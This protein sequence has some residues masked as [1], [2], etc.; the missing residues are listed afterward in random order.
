MEVSNKKFTEPCS[1]GT[2]NLSRSGS[3]TVNEYRLFDLDDVSVY[4][5]ARD[6]FMCDYRESTV[7]KE[8]QCPNCRCCLTCMMDYN[9][10]EC[11]EWEDAVSSTEF[12]MPRPDWKTEAVQATFKRVDSEEAA[13]FIQPPQDSDDWPQDDD[14]QVTGLWPG[15][16]GY[17]EELPP[18]PQEKRFPCKVVGNTIY[19]PDEIW[20]EQEEKP[21]IMDITLPVNHGEYMAIT[22]EYRKKSLYFDRWFRAQ[23]DMRDHEEFLQI[24]NEL[25]EDVKYMV[26]AGGAMSFPEKAPP[27]YWS[28]LLFRFKKQRDMIIH[29]FENRTWPVKA[30]AGVREDTGEQEVNT[31][32]VDQRESTHDDG[33]MT[34]QISAPGHGISMPEGEYH[35][36][37]VMAKPILVSTSQWTTSQETGKQI[38]EVT[39]PGAFINGPHKNLFR[40]FIFTRTEMNITIKV[41]STKFNAGTLLATFVP[42]WFEQ[43]S[44]KQWFA[45]GNLIALPHGKIDA[46]LSN[47]ITLR[48]PFA[49]TLTYFNTA[50]ALPEQQLG[51]LVLS[52]F[53]RLLTTTGASPTVDITIWV[54]FTNCELHQP[55]QLHPIL[56]P[57]VRAEAGVE[58]LVKSV[59]PM[60]AGAIPGGGALTALANTAGNVSGASANCDKPTD[61]Q[62][63]HR[64]VPNAV[65][66]L[67]YGEGIDRTNRLSLKPGTATQHDAAMIQTTEDD[68]SL[69]LLKKVKSRL[70]VFNVSTSDPPGHLCTQ[71]PTYPSLCTDKRENTSVDPAVDVFS[72]PVLAYISRPFKFYRGGLVYTFIAAA[73]QMMACRL[74]ISFIPGQTITNFEEASY[75]NTLI[76]DIQE[77]HEITFTTPYMNNRPWMRCDKLVAVA[78]YKQQ[79]VE[80]TSGMVVVHVV[81]RLTV[82]DAA[83]KSIEVNVLISA[84]DDFELAFPSDLSLYQGSGDVIAEAGLSDTVSARE[85]EPTTI[86]IHGSG[87]LAPASATTLSENAMDLKTVCRRYYK[88]YENVINID[89]NSMI[90][91]VNTP[92]LSS[93]NK[94]FNNN[95]GTQYR[96]HISHFA[97][98]FVFWRGSLRY[99]LT[100]HGWDTT[101]SLTAEIVHVPGVFRNNVTPVNISDPVVMTLGSAEAMGVQVGTTQIQ[102]S[103]QFEIPFYTPFQQLRTQYNGSN[104]TEQEATGTIFIRFNGEK[105]TKHRITLYQALG[106][107]ASFNYFRGVPQVQF[108]NLAEGARDTAPNAPWIYQKSFMPLPEMGIRDILPRNPYTTIMDTVQAIGHTSRTTEELI[109]TIQSKISPA[110]AEEEPPKG[111]GFLDNFLQNLPSL[112]GTGTVVIGSLAA[113]ITG[114]QAFLTAETLIVKASAIVTIIREIFGTAVEWS[115]N[116]LSQL[117][118]TIVT[119]IIGNGAKQGNQ[120][121]E[122][123][124]EAQILDFIPAVIGV[125]TAALVV[126]GFKSI[127]DDKDTKELCNNISNKLRLFNFG[128]SAISNIKT[129]YKEMKEFTE[130]IID[131]V[132]TLTAPQFLA[133]LRLQRGYEEI[134]QWA[135]FI[136]ATDRTDYQNRA[137]YDTD[138][139]NEIY[140]TVDQA[141]T[142]T[143]LMVTGK[144]GREGFIIRDLVRRAYEMGEKVKEAYRTIAFRVDPLCICLHGTTAMG[145]STVATELGMTLLDRLGY[146]RKNRWV[147]HN[148]TDKFF[149]ENYRGQHAVYIDDISLFDNPEQYQNFANLKANTQLPLNMALRKGEYFTSHFLITTTNVKYPV[150]NTCNFNPALQRRRDIMIECSWVNQEVMQRAMAGDHAV[151]E[152]YAHIRFRIIESI[153]PVLARQLG[154]QQAPPTRYMT[155]ADLIEELVVRSHHYLDGQ[156][157][158]VRR[159]LEMQGVP[160]PDELAAINDERR[161]HRAAEEVFH[162]AVQELPGNE[163]PIPPEAWLNRPAP[164]VARDEELVAEEP[165]VALNPL[166]EDQRRLVGPPA[167]AQARVLDMEAVGRMPNLRM[168]GP[169]FLATLSWNDKLQRVESSVQPIEDRVMTEDEV[170]MEAERQA[171]FRMA[172]EQRA[173]RARLMM[174]EQE[175]LELEA[176]QYPPGFVELEFKLSLKQTK[177]EGII[178]AVREKLAKFRTWAEHKWEEIKE[179]LPFLQ[180]FETMPVKLAGAAVAI[181]GLTG[182]AVK[183][184]HKCYCHSVR[185][186]GYRCRLCGRWPKLDHTLNQAWILQ[187]WQRIYGT[188]EY[189][190]GRVTTLEEEKRYRQLE[191]EETI[192]RMTIGTKEAC[193]AQIGPYSDVTRGLHR[194]VLVPHMGPYS[195]VTK[196]VA[197]RR[198]VANS[199][200]SEILD[201]RIYSALHRVKV[202]LGLQVMDINALAVGGKKFLMQK[203]F[204][205]VVERAGEFQLLHSGKWVPVIYESERVKNFPNKDLV[206]VEIPFVQNMK[207]LVN[208]FIEEESLGKIKKT[209]AVVVKVNQGGIPVVIETEAE[210][211]DQMR[212][213]LELNGKTST[214]VTRGMWKYRAVMGPGTC[215]SVVMTT[216]NKTNGLILGLHSAGDA[217]RAI[218]YASLITREMLQG[219]IGDGKLG[220]PLPKAQFLISPLI[221]DGHFGHIGKVER[222]IFQSDKTTIIPTV[223]Q[224]LVAPVK[225]GPAPL[226]SKDPRIEKPTNIIRECISKYG[227]VVKP[228]DIRHRQMISEDLRQEFGTW[229]LARTPAI[230]SNEEALCGIEELPGFDRL[231]LNTSPGYPWVLTRPV[232]A[233]GKAYLFDIDNK[234]ISDAALEK[235]FQERERM[236]LLGE[237]VE[238]VWTCCLKDE[239]RS[240][241]KIAKGNTRLFVIPPVDYSLL[242]RKYML[243][244]SVALKDNRHISSSKVG[245]DPQSLEWTEL[246]NY[247]AQFSNLVFAG[248]FKSFDGTLASDLT[249]DFYADADAFYQLFGEWKEGDRKVRA[250]LSDEGIHTVC[251]A[252]SVA[253]MTHI[254]NKSGN[255][256]TVNKNGDV[257]ARYMKLAYLGLAERNGK[258]ATMAEFRKNVK[259]AVYGDDNIVAVKPDA[260]DWFNQVTVA[261]FL[262]EYGITYTNATKTGDVKPYISLEEMT[263]LKQ[264]FR[265]H[266]SIVGVKVPHMAEQTITELTNWTRIAPDQDE[267]L[268]S[269]CNDALRFAYFRGFDYFNDLRGRIMG[270]LK[271]RGKGQL[272]VQTY[273]DLHF[274]FLYVCGVL[275]CRVKAQAALETISQMGNSEKAKEVMKWISCIPYAILSRTGLLGRDDSKDK[276]DNR[277]AIAIPSGEGKSWLCK[278]FPGLFVD[279]DDILLP[280]ASKR[281]KEKGLDWEYLWGMLE[282]DL[283]LEDRRILL[284]H[285]PGNT[286][287]KVLGSFKLPKPCFIRANA[288]Q[289]LRLKDAVI[290]ERDERNSRILDL[291]K[292]KEHELWKAN[293]SPYLLTAGA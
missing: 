105:S 270:A 132:L 133:Q 204:M 134:E 243:D 235:K 112:V 6:T 199:R 188:E 66:A 115:F 290:M 225:T 92:A 39:L 196:G 273:T 60:V 56:L 278:R 45:D 272:R 28:D 275:P 21:K 78:D 43:Q 50:L 192:D 9:E 119:S 176:A 180:V 224:G 218:G 25:L 253:F 170:E 164:V 59:L 62:D 127:P 3:Q 269:N 219:T 202:I 46:S 167:N 67:N 281:L 130:W 184:V 138:F 20:N 38:L 147:A 48:I 13:N 162:D 102:N 283:P 161:A 212:Y 93:V 156:E 260:I 75:Y 114:F 27:S 256:N 82:P 292:E 91:I 236:A 222:G 153:D 137:T 113:V 210:A 160:M 250:V 197:P 216:E 76:W 215:G 286:R 155:Y 227:Q 140:R 166:P 51:K 175:G 152:N 108:I 274:W 228:F 181:L 88:V 252:N 104:W 151:R 178:T 293:G 285:H 267:L 123:A 19:L 99:V 245:I 244:Y 49:H 31:T 121:P 63:I 74:Q 284:V 71:Y 190:P 87:Q 237:R 117:A 30:E 77:K 106:D 211:I 226:S 57:G 193:I 189:V 255:P 251:L 177:L 47:S 183:A 79:R 247:I 208:H 203:H 209:A 136:E 95:N 96:T 232:G 220:T 70:L 107:D 149:T 53:N 238:S 97:E 254:G 11:M 32:F 239:R 168:F 5:D 18:P 271:Q 141:D 264:S 242:E 148:A 258:L 29:H 17:D 55:S 109:T 163:E 171:F 266:E 165:F 124:A 174:A 249:T 83:A 12:F 248:D 187:E 262:A 277:Y 86:L 36:K 142:Y 110:P 98:Q 15:D 128:S 34:Q 1:H 103:F 179:K 157:R 4:S 100:I 288:Y 185:S 10:C 206:L 73:N 287:R 200:V 182:L 41:N 268:E 246:Y 191:D 139:R 65:T 158:L 143:R 231:P 207:S 186:F 194:G 261:D 16:N 172:E 259:L 81:N 61:P 33:F 265:D 257:N 122:V 233:T 213:D 282:K 146:P 90:S 2:Q 101:K 85:E 35:V 94:R 145:K 54:A 126:F 69:H 279:H 280:E 118:I 42:L 72:A 40:T 52:V 289:R 229:K 144:I 89:E 263:F 291:I 240:F 150:L 234:K 116:K 7:D 125:A 205:D 241:E 159:N 80:L 223:I 120:A 221:P 135:Q 169:D 26:S 217:G 198:V 24:F 8:D 154:I 14:Q 195:D 64:W 23:E 276:T 230:L 58:G 173:E 214:Y 68:M 44:V 84:A 22:E 37:T 129:L 201:N 111:L 131:Q